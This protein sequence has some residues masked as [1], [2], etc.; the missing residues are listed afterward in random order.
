MVPFL[1][2]NESNYLQLFR[3]YASLCACSYDSVIDCMLFFVTRVYGL[4]NSEIFALSRS[5][6]ER[7]KENC[8][9]WTC[10]AVKNLPIAHRVAVQRNVS[11]GLH[12]A[13]LLKS[14]TGFGA[15]AIIFTR[16]ASANLWFPACA[17]I[18]G[19]RHDRRAQPS[20]TEPR[21]PDDITTTLIHIKHRL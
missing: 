17:H 21:P 2:I 13:T 19:A 20:H 7:D 6:L 18:S 14:G 11:R 3:R 16:G 10:V 8:W 5:E 12:F 4:R 15:S 1:F 9:R